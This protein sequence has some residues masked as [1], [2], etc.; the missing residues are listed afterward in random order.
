VQG[1]RPL[2]PRGLQLPA[3]LLDRR[4]RRQLIVRPHRLTR[5]GRRAPHL[6]VNEFQQVLEHLLEQ[7]KVARHRDFDRPLPDRLVRA[8]LQDKGVRARRAPA[9]RHPAFHNARAAALE[10]VL[11]KVR[12]VRKDPEPAFRKPSRASLCMRANL[13]RR[14]GAR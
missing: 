9:G 14:V 13:P 7:P 10:V 2:P 4:A 12:L 11:G 3:L 6:R 1:L 8:A 5:I